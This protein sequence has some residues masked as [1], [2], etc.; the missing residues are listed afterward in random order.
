M[1]PSVQ[2]PIEINFEHLIILS[3][4]IYGVFALEK[5]D[6]TSQTLGVADQVSL[7]CDTIHQTNIQM[8]LVLLHYKS[9]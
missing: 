2:R 1:A 6:V 8:N 7:L 9:P 4:H 5:F 3:P